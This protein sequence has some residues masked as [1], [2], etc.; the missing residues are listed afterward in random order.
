VLLVGI[1][2]AIVFA[3]TLVYAPFLHALFGTAALSADQLLLVVPF[4]F[5]V[6]GADELRRLWRRRDA[7]T[8]QTSAVNAKS[9]RGPYAGEMAGRYASE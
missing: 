9:T 1:A 7:P 8:P 5:I 2:A 4:P 3:L 6:W